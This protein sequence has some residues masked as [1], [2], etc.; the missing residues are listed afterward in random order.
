M[1]WCT[2]DSAEPE[3]DV[4]RVQLDAAGAAAGVT[5]LGSVQV[6]RRDA[7]QGII[8]FRPSTGSLRDGFS[9][10]DS[11]PEGLCPVVGSSDYVR[12]VPISGLQSHCTGVAAVLLS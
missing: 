12:S 10:T 1:L 3:L 5:V 9:D 8:P 6:L 4:L 2:T 7:R 11:D